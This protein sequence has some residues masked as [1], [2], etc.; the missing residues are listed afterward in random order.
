MALFV[1]GSDESAGRTQ[2]DTFIFGGWLAPEPD[3]S[4][5]FAPAWQERVLDG[6]P[7]IPHLHMTDIRSPRWR[8]QYGISKLD[9]DDRIDS[10]IHLIDTMASLYPIGIR[11]DAGFL[12]DRFANIKVKTPRPNAK[13]SAFEPDF[14]CFLFY[15][16][17]ALNYLKLFHPDAEKLDF[18]VERNGAVTKHIQDFH[19]TLAENLGALG[20][21]SLADLVGEIVP[22]GKDRVPLQA[23][24][25][26]CWHTARAQHPETMDSADR[27]RYSILAHREGTYQEFTHEQISQMAKSLGV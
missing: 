25:V 3:W 1:S 5:F 4:R 8:D 6:P 18:V 23:A 11:V 9:A 7:K 12:R 16:W 14:T 27:R 24:D 13:A 26:L 10:A 21:A 2:R 15:S 20:D 17:I 19:S 22:G